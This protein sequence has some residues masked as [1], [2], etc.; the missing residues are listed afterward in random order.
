[1]MLKL[2]ES[3]KF[4]EVNAWLKNKTKNLCTWMWSICI[5]SLNLK[6]KQPQTAR[7][8]GTEANAKENAQMLYFSK[9][10]Y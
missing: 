9:F 5:M 7:Q 8:P 2:R 4:M 3:G 1:M 10:V 6:N